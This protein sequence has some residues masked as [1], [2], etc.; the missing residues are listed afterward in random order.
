MR[1]RII[2]GNWKMNKTFQDADDLLIEITE[3]LLDL[4]LKGVEVVVCPPSVYL[5][6]AT[7][8]AENY[9]ISVG[10]QNISDKSFGAYTGEISAP[11]LKSMN[12]DYCIIG[13]SERRQYFNESNEQLKQKVY[14]ALENDVIPIFC[15]GELLDQ[16]QAGNHFKVIEKQLEESVFNLEDFD[17]QKL[18]IAYEP[19]WAIGTGVTASPAQAEEM[20][21]YIRS[22]IEK[23][24]NKDISE[25]TT[26]LYGG[27]CNPSNAAEL[28]S[29]KDVDGGL[30]GGASLN[31]GDF[32]EIINQ[33]IKKQ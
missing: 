2:A 13:H 32:L 9:P 33:R 11:M 17:F 12:V 29:I 6:L 3:E 31:A 23:K 16:R 5:E 10:A 27:S 8:A 19:V 18:V 4:D 21:T 24:Y 1:K 26:I 22:L 28:F 30:I 25:G 7:D 14:Q 20:H 15:I